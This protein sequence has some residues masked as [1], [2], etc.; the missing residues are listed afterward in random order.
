MCKML[1]ILLRQSIQS[2]QD[3]AAF[4]ITHLKSVFWKLLTEF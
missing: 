2:S 3:Y 1:G 4:Q